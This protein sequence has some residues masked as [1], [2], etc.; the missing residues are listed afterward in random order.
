MTL[1]CQTLRAQGFTNTDAAAAKDAEARTDTQPFD[2]SGL[3]RESDLH[4]ALMHRR[5]NEYTYTLVKI[6][7][8]LNDHN[9]VTRE[10]VQ[11]FEA[12]PC[13]GQHVLIQLSQN[14]NALPPDEVA[15]QRRLA[16]EELERAEREA[17]KRREAVAAP[18]A[19]AM[20]AT[21]NPGKYLVAGI[22]VSSNGK[23]LNALIDLSE[24]LRSGE[25]SNPHRDMLG[26]REAIVLN[27]RSRADVK[28]PANMSFMSKL[29]GTVWIDAE[30]KVVVR[31]EGW[32]VT[33]TSP[34]A[35][36]ATADIKAATE[37]KTAHEVQDSRETQDSSESQAAIIYQQ[38]RLPTGV[39][40]PSL[41]RMNAG[42][43]PAL[44]NG[45][46]WDVMF[47]FSDYKRYST[48]VEGV[49][50]EKPAAKSRP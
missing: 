10:V 16:G 5:L 11:S 9:K 14:G 28:F 35:K 20:E 2:I 30:D 25:F 26:K 45:L 38:V 3:V 17:L 47:R 23:Y 27:F 32:P 13:P 44:F 34:E 6:K 7:R 46:N 36:P 18:A 40:V 29:S 8:V 21:D 1:D 39:W 43:D 31:L 24:F 15:T 19:A 22:S 48:D 4:G 37:M 50:L 42:G 33:A 12:Y 49:Q 41:I